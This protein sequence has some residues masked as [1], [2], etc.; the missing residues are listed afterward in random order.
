[1][2]RKVINYDKQTDIL[3]LY[4]NDNSIED[5]D[6]IA[7]GVIVD[8]DADGHV[9]GVEILD[10]FDIWSKQFTSPPLTFTTIWSEEDQEFVG[11][12]DRYPS[13]SWLDKDEAKARQGIIDLVNVIEGKRGRGRPKGAK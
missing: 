10:A 11:L 2:N 6:E 9:V 13:L 4:F 1:M 5:S 3:T 8:Y 12:C 7:P